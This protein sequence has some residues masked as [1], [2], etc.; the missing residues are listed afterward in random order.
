MINPLF[1]STATIDT[2]QSSPHNCPNCRCQRVRNSPNPYTTPFH[3]KDNNDH[4][5]M[6]FNPL[7]S[8]FVRTAPNFNESS[9]STSKYN[10]TF[11]YSSPIWIKKHHSS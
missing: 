2:R 10:I 11:S 3:P 9:R 1:Y 6:T 8:L 5:M 4:M 7:K